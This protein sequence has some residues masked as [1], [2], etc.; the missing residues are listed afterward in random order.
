[1]GQPSSTRLTN[2]HGVADD[3]DARAARR[4]I[5]AAVMFADEQQRLD[6][7]RV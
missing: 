5:A 1:M 4:A 3:K 2:L 7:T 6:P